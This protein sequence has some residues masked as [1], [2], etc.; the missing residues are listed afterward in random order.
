VQAQSVAAESA[1]DQARPFAL[2]QA[3]PGNNLRLRFA[4]L[5][6]L[7][8]AA[9]LALAIVNLLIGVFLR[10]V[11]VEVTDFLDV[12]PIS[13]FWVEEL[14]EFTLAWLTLI[15]AAVGVVTG[16]HFT[17]RVVVHRL[18]ARAQRVITVVNHLLIGGFGLL[19]AWQAWRLTVVNSVLASPGLEVNLGWLYFSAVIGGAMIAFYAF[20]VAL[21]FIRPAAP[22]H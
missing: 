9:L 3:R 8:I 7:V 5:P 20:A 13:F 10:Y 17:L 19:A 2:P 1:T 21:G 16:T 11:M 12:D 18:P 4:D 6:K 22:E 14:G 15:G